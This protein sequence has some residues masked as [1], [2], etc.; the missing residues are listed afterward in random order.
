MGNTYNYLFMME[1]QEGLNIFFEEKHTETIHEQNCKE[2]PLPE[3]L[4]YLQRGDSSKYL[5]QF[6]VKN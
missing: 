4:P 3:S 1:N 2:E 6:L 5:D